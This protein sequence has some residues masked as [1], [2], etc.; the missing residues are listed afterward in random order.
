MD[1]FKINEINTGSTFAAPL[2][3]DPHFLL[4]DANIPISENLKKAL[5]EWG[6]KEVLSDSEVKEKKEPSS[7]MPK[8]K[9][10]VDMSSFETVDLDAVL[11][12]DEEKPQKDNTGILINKRFADVIEKALTEI[13]K[14]QDSDIE[15]R[16]SISTEVYNAFKEYI[17]KIYTRFVTHRELKIGLLSEAIIKI[18]DFM[19]SYKKY[20]LQINPVPTEV[21]DK[22]YLVNHSLRATLYALTIG[23]NLRMQTTQLVELGVAS[24]LH[25]IGQTRL[26]PQLYLT[27]RRLLPNERAMLATHTVIGFNILKENNFPISIQM[28]VLEHHERE[29]GKG[30]P[31]GRVGNQISLYGKILAV[32]C[33]FE[34]ISAPRLY[35]EM[36]STHEAM[37]EMLKNADKQ[38]DDIVI[39]ALVQSISLYPIG[40]YVFLANGKVAKVVDVNGRDPRL[41]IVQILGERDENGFPRTLQTNSDK[42]KIIRALNKNEIQGVLKTFKK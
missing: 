26:P 41:P 23:Q 39:K 1:A 35:K 5:I 33:S 42:F 21:V 27:T 32:V 16:I 24:L 15:S 34:A 25:E 38:Y 18:C 12:D 20:L 28:G 22:N 6:F 14:T 4:L 29:N 7:Q 30:Y 13:E 17:S 37:I 11:S 36:R 2:F 31:R 9:P 19:K 8:S 10:S 40:G 3:L